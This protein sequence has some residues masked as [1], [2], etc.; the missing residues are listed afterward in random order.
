[1]NQE[2]IS[3]MN[4][5]ENLPIDAAMLRTTSQ[6]RVKDESPLMLRTKISK[7]QEQT[8]RGWLCSQNT[9]N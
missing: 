9:M 6:S 5:Q 8:S 2:G 7:F 3:E 1:M 4:L